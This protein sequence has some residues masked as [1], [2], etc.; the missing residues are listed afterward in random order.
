MWKVKSYLLVEPDEP[1]LYS[2][3]EEAEKD[4]DQDMFL[5]P[6]EILSIVVECDENGEEV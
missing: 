2:T 1:V 4:A 3:K 6:G 5:Q